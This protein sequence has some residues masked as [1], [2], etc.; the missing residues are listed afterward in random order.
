M[1]I[2]QKLTR[3]ECS[4][5][6]LY[7]FHEDVSNLPLITP[8]GIEVTLLDDISSV[9]EGDVL[10]MKVK[11]FFVSIPW[12][13]KITKAHYPDILIDSAVKSPFKSWEHQ[14]IFSQKEDSCE[15]KDIVFYELPLG[16]LGRLFSRIVASQLEEMFTFRHEQTKKILEAKDKS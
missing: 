15:L 5:E 9:K 1:Y 13:I 7:K 11:Q 4:L 6:G 14:H 8:K 16:F 12:T 10:H 3:I 2:F